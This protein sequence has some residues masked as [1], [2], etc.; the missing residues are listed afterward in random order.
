MPESPSE[1]LFPPGGPPPFE[2]TAQERTRLLVLHLTNWTWEE[3]LSALQSRDL[4]CKRDLTEREGRTARREV[5]QWLADA[6]ARFNP[7]IADGT[8][9]RMQQ[10]YYERRARMEPIDLLIDHAHH[11]HL[12]DNRGNTAPLA[13]PELF[14]TKRPWGEQVPFAE[15]VPRAWEGVFTN[16]CVD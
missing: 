7:K 11:S 10:D 14:R 5:A 8:F 16:V 1:P 12:Y 4:R 2:L 9:A 15:L 13:F 3:R 6:V